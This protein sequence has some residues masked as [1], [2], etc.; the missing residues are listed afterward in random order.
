MVSIPEMGEVVA[1]TVTG[2]LEHEG[3]VAKLGTGGAGRERDGRGSRKRRREGRDCW[4][5]E[6]RFRLLKASL[7]LDCRHD[8]SRRFE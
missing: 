5:V 3:R 4:R 2:G 8:M 7:L 6:R 1:D